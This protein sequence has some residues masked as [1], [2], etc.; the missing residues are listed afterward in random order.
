MARGN[1]AGNRN[2][3]SSSAEDRLSVLTGKE[4]GDR[5][6]LAAYLA[7]ETLSDVVNWCLEQSIEEYIRTHRVSIPRVRPGRR[8][9]L[10]GG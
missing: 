2:R 6:R 9:R 4:L 8:P 10:P 5:V 1:G 7:N 3:T